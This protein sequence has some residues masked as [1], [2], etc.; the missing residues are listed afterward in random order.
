MGSVVRCG[1]GSGRGGDIDIA[2]AAWVASSERVERK[3]GGRQ[4]ALIEHGEDSDVQACMGWIFSSSF[5]LYLASSFS[6]SLSSAVILTPFSL[7]QIPD[8]PWLPLLDLRISIRFDIPPSRPRRR[9]TPNPYTPRVLALVLAP[10]Y[11]TSR[12][13]RADGQRQR[14]L[15]DLV[16]PPAQPHTRAER[17]HLPVGAAAGRNSW[18]LR[19]WGGTPLPP[20]PSVPVD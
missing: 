12:A 16:P 8:P 3:V 2:A 7:S 1:E 18:R 11:F 17:D 4:Y 6:F 5:Y 10:T 20:P 13:D 15:G 14:W 19:G 9:P